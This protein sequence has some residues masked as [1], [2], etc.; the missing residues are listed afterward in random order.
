M[1]PSSSIDVIAFEAVR[2]TAGI[3]TA[4]GSENAKVRKVPKV[5]IAHL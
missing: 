4:H 1:L 2:R 5:R 3:P